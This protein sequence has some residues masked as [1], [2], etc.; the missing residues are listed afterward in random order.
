MVP[1]E[2]VLEKYPWKHVLRLVHVAYSNT[3]EGIEKWRIRNGPRDKRKRRPNLT[4]RWKLQGRGLANENSQLPVRKFCVLR[5]KDDASRF[6]VQYAAQK[7]RPGLQAEG[8]SGT[9][10][11]SLIA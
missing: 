4:I 9:T 8:A 3:S 7:R 6:L 1:G 10:R 11:A 2:R 5:M